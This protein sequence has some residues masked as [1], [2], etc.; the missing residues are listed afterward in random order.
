MLDVLEF[1]YDKFYKALRIQEIQRVVVAVVYVSK[2]T[3]WPW[4][5]LMVRRQAGSKA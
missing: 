3:R 5:S 1:F 2:T 4:H